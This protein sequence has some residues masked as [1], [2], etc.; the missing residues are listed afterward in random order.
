MRAFIY[1]L[2]GVNLE[3]FVDALMGKKIGTEFGEGFISVNIPGISSL[4]QLL[5]PQ[6]A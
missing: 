4:D 5:Y 6:L 3:V 1:R 2:H